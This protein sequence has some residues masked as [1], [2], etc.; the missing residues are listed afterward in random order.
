MVKDNRLFERKL[1]TILCRVSVRLTRRGPIYIPYDIPNRGEQG[2]G[3]GYPRN[4][5]YLFRPGKKTREETGSSGPGSVSPS[6]R[7]VVA[8]CLLLASVSQRGP[9]SIIF[10]PLHFFVPG[11]SNPHIRI[12]EIVTLIQTDKPVFIPISSD[13]DDFTSK[14]MSYSRTGL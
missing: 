9:T 14:S 5:G 6:L 3:V 8:P 1:S 4:H 7:S 11:N 2:M 13:T 12:I 10:G